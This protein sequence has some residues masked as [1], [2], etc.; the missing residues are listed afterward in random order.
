MQETAT[1]FDDRPVAKTQVQRL[2][3]YMR[4]G[5][6]ITVIEAYTKLRITQ[7]GRCIKDLEAQG[8]VFERPR[9][10][11]ESGKSVCR[12]KMVR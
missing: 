11:V 10:T 4:Y 2:L 6:T 12:Y 5:K 8:H 7:L 9:I 3:E 1:L